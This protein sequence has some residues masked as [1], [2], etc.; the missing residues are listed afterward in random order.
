MTIKL[1]LE[2]KEWTGR[3]RHRCNQTEVS[4]TFLNEKLELLVS[5]NP[6]YHRPQWKWSLEVPYDGGYWSVELESG[7]CGGTQDRDAAKAYAERCAREYFE[8]LARKLTR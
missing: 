2:W 1:A 6:Q 7:D 8:G 5:R 4:W 3:I